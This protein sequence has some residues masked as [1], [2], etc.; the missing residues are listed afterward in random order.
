[1]AWL[2]G[3]D[4]KYK[5]VQEGFRAIGYPTLEEVCEKNDGY[6]ILRYPEGVEIQ[7]I[8]ILEAVTKI[9][10][11]EFLDDIEY[12]ECMIIK[13]DNAIWSGM[14]SCH[15]K[16]TPKKT[17]RDLKVQFRLPYVAIKSK[18]LTRDNFGVTLSVYLHEIAH[19]FGGDRSASFS[20]ALTEILEISLQN[21]KIIEL[22][23]LKWEK[24]FD[25]IKK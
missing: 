6:S 23:R 18:L 11:I 2:R 22:F 10:L 20:H 14:A 9:I 25:E 24:I 13:T 3:S 8:K 21:T 15:R 12:P 4:K 5:L 1:M 17:D 19:I 7:L 16:S